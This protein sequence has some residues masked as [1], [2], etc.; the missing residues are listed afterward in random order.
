MAQAIWNGQVIAQSD[1][2]ELVEGNIYFPRAA[3]K[4]EFF[5]DSAH[6]TVCSWKG[7]AS[8]FDVVVNGKVNANAAWYYATPKDAASNIAGYVAFWKGVEVTQ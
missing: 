1:S 2:F 4:A 7:T 8:Y 3:L 5:Q 6:A